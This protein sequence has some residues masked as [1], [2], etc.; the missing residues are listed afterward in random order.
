MHRG[1]DGAE[2]GTGHDDRQP[3]RQQTVDE[4]GPRR[5]QAREKPGARQQERDLQEHRDDR[6]RVAEGRAGEQ[7]AHQVRR[8]DERQEQERAQQR[9][10]HRLALGSARSPPVPVP[11]T[12]DDEQQQERRERQRPEE[13][14]G[15]V[16][17]DQHGHRD[18]PDGQCGDADHPARDGPPAGVQREQ[19]EQR[20]GEDERGGRAGTLVRARPHDVGELRGEVHDDEGDHPPA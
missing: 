11:L 10:P 12:P 16:G 1:E 4:L 7:D 3:Q 2:H 5:D 15:D 17:A 13:A 18:Q 9:P 20:R 6:R 14:L 8:D 19:E